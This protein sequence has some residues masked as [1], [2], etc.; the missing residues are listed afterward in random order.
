MNNL[1]QN[2]QWSENVILADA[3][4]IDKVAFHLIT[5]FE[6]MLERRIP[7]ADLAKWAECV[8]LDG[9]VPTLDTTKDSQTSDQQT[10]VVLVHP[11]GKDKL[12]N[13]IPSVFETELNGMAF[14]GS[15]GEFLV[16]AYP[17]EDAVGGE[18]YLTEVL[19]LLMTQ[20]EVKRIMVV[21]YADNALIYNKVRDLLNRREHEDKYITVFTMEPMP[22]GKFY[23][24]ILGYSVL[25]A[26]GIKSEEIE[27]KVKKEK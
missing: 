17:I 16:N 6:R 27:E 5:N 3:D 9:R 19:E 22:G 7:Q 25:A 8:A 12:E 14:K 23:Q 13:F 26:L 20:K 18:D 24:E 15:L 4:Y 11:K 10:Q 2:I 1:Q 21:P